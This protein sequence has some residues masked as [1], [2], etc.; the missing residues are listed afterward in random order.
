MRYFRCTQCSSLLQRPLPEPGLLERYY[1]SYLDI[2]A[3]MNPGYLE[4]DTFAA[5]C[6]ERDLTFKEIGFD[7]QR[8]PSSRN[9]ELG[10]AN[11]LFL[12]YLKDSGSA[13]TVGIDISAALL[14]AIRLQDVTLIKGSLDDLADGAADHLF[15]FNVLEHLPD[16]RSACVSAARV[17]APGGY[18]V[19]EVPLA[20]L[21]SCWHG[22]RWR[23]LMG[24]EHLN[25]PSKRALV[26]LC[27]EQGL[28]LRGLTRFGSGYTSGTL[29]AP[30][31]RIADSLAKRWGIGDR[32]C[33][34]FQKAPAGS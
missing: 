23:F 11:G 10:C 8:I 1:E 15:M 14:A 4:G 33:F 31:K 6:R 21:L 22:R 7:R 26:G 28:R 19:I 5:L 9:V 3:V 16:V 2:K 17:L 12:K 20:G 24:D 30:L 32:G 25:I 29:S 18:A 34:L 27:R 13:Q